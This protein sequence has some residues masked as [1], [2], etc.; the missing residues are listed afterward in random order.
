VQV[1]PTIVKALG[2]NPAALDAVQQE[3]TAVLPEVVLQLAK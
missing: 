1:A 2:L 3:G